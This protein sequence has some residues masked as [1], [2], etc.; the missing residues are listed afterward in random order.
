MT[1]VA[2]TGLGVVTCHGSGTRALWDAMMA[3]PVTDPGPVS[4]PFAHM[5]V[6]VVQGVSEV[7]LPAESQALAR[8]SR[9]ALT[10]V[11]EALADAGLPL[12][13]SAGA[14][15]ARIGLSLG[16]CMG[17]SGLHEQWRAD[18]GK[19]AER[20]TSALGVAGEI[21]DRLGPLSVATTIS[22]A[23]AAGGF[24][25]GA[26]ADLVRSGEA[27]I[28]LAVGADAYSRVMLACFNRMGAVD[29]VRCRPFDL[30]RRGTSF[31]EAA[32][33][34]VVEST[35]HARARGATVRAVVEGSGWTC[36]AYHLTAPE[37]GGTQIIRAMRAALDETGTDSDRIGCVLPHGTGT[38][39]N[40]VVESRALN[41]VLGV[42]VPLYS[43]KALIGHTG[44]AA[45]AVAAVAAALILRYRTVP[46]NVPITEQDPECRV[47]LPQGLVTPLASDR[48]MVNGYA[49]GGNN[50]S[51][52]LAG[53][54]T[55]AGA[56]TLAGVG[57]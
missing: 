56:E 25:L 50:V 52:V 39:L 26:A 46:P 48:I 30:H 53:A 54:G 16:T 14:A 23:C 6:P 57:T 38:Q 51:L 35:E 45:A 43:L 55:L 47:W 8:T 34:L 20:F 7:Y 33:A 3:A 11:D 24:A 49:F 44:G 2:I 12:A 28:V 13:E 42:D 37:P 27:D 40:D 15:R 9:L 41:E 1:G 29:P 5:D 32:G 21:A 17:D 19:P 10:A 36:D 31:G 22:N 4:D 18:G